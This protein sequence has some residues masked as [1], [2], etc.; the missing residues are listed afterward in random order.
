MPWKRAV[1]LA[2]LAAGAFAATDSS[3]LAGAGPAKPNAFLPPRELKSLVIKP[4]AEPPYPVI[5]AV[6][7]LVAGLI[8]AFQRR[9][10][11]I[12]K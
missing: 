9:I 2:C 1:L 5:L 8:V 10:V 4:M 7:L 11:G 3:Q 6:D 12:L